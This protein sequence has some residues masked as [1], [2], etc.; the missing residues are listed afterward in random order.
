MQPEICKLGQSYDEWY[1]SP[2]S[3]YTID[4]SESRFYHWIISLFGISRA[5]QGL[6]LLDMACGVGKFLSL[7]EEYG[8]STYGMDISPVAIYQAKQMAS[9]TDLHVGDG[10][11]LP[12]ENESFDYVT[13]LG[14]LEHFPHPEKGASEITR[15]LKPDGLAVVY[16]PNEFFVGHIYMA[17]RYG[18]EPTEGEQ[19]FSERF[20]TRLGWQSLLEQ[21]GL[22]VVGVHKYNRIGATQKISPWL[23]MLYNL[24][25]RPF[26][27]LNLSYCFAFVCR[28]S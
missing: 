3:R 15:V 10:E 25:L 18:I 28:K 16:L 9:Q 21:S 7:A 23:V 24:I 26:I 22:K 19:T 20:S 2:G 17:F 5:V 11:H 12:Y 27:P 4:R 1:V 14:S 6:K 13:N 8:I